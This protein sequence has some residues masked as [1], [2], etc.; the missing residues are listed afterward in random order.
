MNS[1]LNTFFNSL[2]EDRK[3]LLATVRNLS[4]EK[5]LHAPEGKWSIHQI[6][7]HIIAAEKLSVMY[8]NKKYWG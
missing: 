5:Q 3:N 6:L 2:E 8:L 4:T 7:A 1:K